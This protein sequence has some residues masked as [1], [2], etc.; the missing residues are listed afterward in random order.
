VLT[1]CDL[2]HRVVVRRFAGVGAV[3]R[4]Q[5]TDVLGLLISIDD[6]QLT[7]RKEDGAE[8]AIATSEVQAAKR[9]PPR[10]ARYSE[11]VALELTADRAWP[12][13]TVEHLGDW[14]LRSAQGWTNRANSALPVGDAGLPL[15]AAIAACIRWYADRGQTPMITV[16]LPLRR[17]VESALTARAWRS[18]PVI[19][20]Q[21][22]DVDDILARAATEPAHAPPAVEFT[23]MPSDA[24]LA[25]LGAG[26]SAPPPAA[27]A[28]LTGPDQVRFA[29]VRDANGALLASARGAVVDGCLHLGLLDVVMHAR[30][31][32]LAQRI[33]IGLAAWARQV[34]ARRAV[35]QVEERNAPAVALYQRLGFRT[36]HRYLTYRAPTAPPGPTL[37]DQGQVNSMPSSTGLAEPASWTSPTE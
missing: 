29:E 24:L 14:L 31:R 12:A 32:G 27:L 9:V 25:A 5:F 22:A 1:A 33:T 35:L 15:D 21:V 20:V 28:V 7:L 2:G 36:H 19:L 23:A 6:E 17:D 10:P 26:K 34:G 3:G 4:P 18:Y 8:I 37:V 11:I 16:P 13:P 30:R